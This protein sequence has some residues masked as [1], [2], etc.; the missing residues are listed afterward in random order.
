MNAAVAS[1]SAIAAY[2]CEC[3]RSE[4]FSPSWMVNPTS[5]WSQ[6][7]D[8]GSAACRYSSSARSH[9]RKKRG[10]HHG[11]CQ[12]HC[13]ARD[14]R[15]RFKG[16]AYAAIH[17]N[18]VFFLYAGGPEV[19]QKAS[20]ESFC[21]FPEGSEGLAR[22]FH[23]PKRNRTRWTPRPLELGCSSHLDRM[24]VAFVRLAMWTHCR[25]KSF[26]CPR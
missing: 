26:R 6:A 3:S 4:R 23:S 11:C 18:G 5:S 16:I 22:R 25:Q 21:A 19:G 7:S 15:L 1:F 8:I 13:N 24:W 10:Y 17:E 12:G 14:E 2:A 20:R 9:G